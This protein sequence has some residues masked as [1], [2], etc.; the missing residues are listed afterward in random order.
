M[1]QGAQT[2]LYLGNWNVSS[3]TPGASGSS[4]GESPLI[5]GLTGAEPVSGRVTLGHFDL[6]IDST[7]RLLL[8][9]AVPRF[10]GF[11][12]IGAGRTLAASG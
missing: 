12:T 11:S 10:D 1:P 5:R 8:D 7:S 3:A 2:T 6:Q 4:V 9:S